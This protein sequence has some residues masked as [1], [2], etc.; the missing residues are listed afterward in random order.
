MSKLDF[1][2]PLLRK[3]GYEV[4][5]PAERDYNCIAWAFGDNGDKNRWWWPDKYLQY[6]WPSNVTRDETLESF[7]EAFENMGFEICEKA[8]LEEGFEKIS[9]YTKPDHTPTHVTR[10]LENGKWTSKLGQSEDIEHNFDSLTGQCYGAVA[11]IMKH[12]IQ[13]NK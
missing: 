9:I 2:F 1:V 10:Q 11:V 12:P 3:E 5:S 4:T 7:I 6:Y 13:K 8:E